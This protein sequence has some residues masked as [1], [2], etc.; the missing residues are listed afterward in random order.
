M[1]APC[2]VTGCSRLSGRGA[3]GYCYMHRERIRRTGEPG[4]AE[5]LILLGVVTCSVEG[6][7]RPHFAR[8]YCKM[9]RRRV[10]VNGEPGPAQSRR[11]GRM[12]HNTN[13]GRLV[14][15]SGY[16]VVKCPGHVE[17]R[18]QGWALEHRVVMSDH[19]GRPLL[20]HE[21][22]HHVN[23]DKADNRIEN[24][25]LWSSSQP[26]GQ[27]VADKIAWAREILALYDP[28]SQSR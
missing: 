9:H 16:V 20:A 23:G 13:T 25:E 21:T 10:E 15:A 4:P 5:P 26:P 11:P 19:L 14:Y 24:L 1:G 17:A 8:G 27:R 2:I 28:S 12:A 6:C 18:Q 22:V 3:R 7:D